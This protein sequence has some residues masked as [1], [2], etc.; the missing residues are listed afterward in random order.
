MRSTLL[1]VGVA[2]AVAGPIAAQTPPWQDP[3]VFERSREAPRA[4][5]VPMDEDGDAAPFVISLDGAWRFRYAG[6]MLSMVRDF[7]APGFTDPFW[8]LRLT[9]FDPKAAASGPSTAYL[10]R[11]ETSWRPAAWRSAKP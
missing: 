7:F 11:G 10:Y 8:R 5:F 3:T 1:A 4:T 2:L 6:D 9:H